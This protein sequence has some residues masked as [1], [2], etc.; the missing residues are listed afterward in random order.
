LFQKCRTDALDAVLV[1]S[2][3][4]VTATGEATDAVLAAS[5]VTHVGEVSAFVDVFA[6][7]VAGAFRTQF[8]ES[9]CSRFWTRV[10][11]VSPSFADGAAAHALQ[12]VPF[13]LFGADAVPV[14]QVTR[15]LTLVDAA[16]SSFVQGQ[17]GRTGTGERTFRVDTDAASFTN[18]RIQVAFV[19]IRACFAVHLSNE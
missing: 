7:D 8:F 14:V 2:V 16:R 17:S 15:F 13:D 6:V 4:L 9:G 18:A 1:E 11:T 19:Y 10:A 3:A 5:I 12:V